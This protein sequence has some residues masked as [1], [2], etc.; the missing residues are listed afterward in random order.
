MGGKNKW[1][2]ACTRMRFISFVIIYCGRTTE[3]NNLSESRL[4]GENFLLGILST[5]NF[6]SYRYTYRGPSL[7]W[8]QCVECCFRGMDTFIF[9]QWEIEIKSLELRERNDQKFRVYDW[10]CEFTLLSR[11]MLKR[12][13]YFSCYLLTGENIDFNINCS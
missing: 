3:K 7:R 2:S 4:W 10:A 5:P 8:L 9:W 1:S 12:L 13:Y 6:N 11:N